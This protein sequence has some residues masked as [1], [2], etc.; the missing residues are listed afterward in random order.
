MAANIIIYSEDL[1]TPI[2]YPR[3]N[4]ERQN[5]PRTDKNWSSFGHPFIPT[6]DSRL[7]R[8]FI[9]LYVV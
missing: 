8:V 6:Y 2:L 1:L 9:E 7:N 3:E 5:A 4:S